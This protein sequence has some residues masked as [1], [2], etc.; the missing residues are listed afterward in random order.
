MTTPQILTLMGPAPSF[1]GGTTSVPV[2][3]L[4]T[5]KWPQR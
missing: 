3:T 2:G 4:G 5:L 1:V